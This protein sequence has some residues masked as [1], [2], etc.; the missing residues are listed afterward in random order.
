LTE[1]VPHPETH[2]EVVAK[3]KALMEEL[4]QCPVMVKKEVDGFCSN[5]MQYAII[6]EAWRLVEVW[7][8]ASTHL[9]CSVVVVPPEKSS[10]HSRVFLHECWYLIGA[11]LKVKKCW[12]ASEL[13]FYPKASFLEF[14]AC[15]TV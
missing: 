15:Q 12:R 6:N 10:L 4:G 8:L 9:C 13:Y 5:P 7:R 14:N 2:P 1:I 3:T 11:Y